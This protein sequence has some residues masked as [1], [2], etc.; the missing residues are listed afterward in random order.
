MGKVVMVRLDLTIL[1]RE[2]KKKHS[3]AARV[4]STIKYLHKAGAKLILISS[5][6]ARA[7]SQLL[8]LERVAGLQISYFS[9]CLCCFSPY[10]N[11]GL[12]SQSIKNCMQDTVTVFI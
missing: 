2:Q 3:S 8:K 6:S 5:W 11:L 9:L 7:D 12:A 4:I 10:E 1:L